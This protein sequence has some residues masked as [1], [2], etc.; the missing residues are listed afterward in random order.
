MRQSHFRVMVAHSRTKAALDQLQ[1]AVGMGEMNKEMGALI[2][3]ASASLDDA[4]DKL[5][6][7]MELMEDSQASSLATAV[8][9]ARRR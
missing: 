9:E 7:A 6:Q 3:S 1:E 8:E 2:T 5:R 4:S